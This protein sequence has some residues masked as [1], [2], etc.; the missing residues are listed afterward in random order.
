M[1][2][3]EL[4][5]LQ[6]AFGRA[7]LAGTAAPLTAALVSDRIPAERRFAVHVNT[8]YGLLG[9]ALEAAFP[10][11]C[12]LVGTPFFRMTTR[13]F[14]ADHPPEVP[15]L[16]VFGD[17]FPD[18]LASFPPAAG[19]PY[20]AGVA[21]LEWARVEA[22]FAADASPLDP[23]TLQSVPPE[24]VAALVFRLHPSVRLIRSPWPICDVW[25][26]HLQ[27]PVPPVDVTKGGQAALVLRPADAVQVVALLP[28]DAAL[29]DA[30]AGGAS[31]AA[32]ASAAS[33]AEPG[34]DLQA[35]L[36]GHLARGTFTG[37]A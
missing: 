35:A 23:A 7:L 20:L 26:A 33:E 31:L 10:V 18:F 21:R 34:F 28:G 36:A 14:I 19:V 6:A 8:V 9:D 17:R 3:P 25:F 1:P 22:G 12:R 30:I 5:E 37:H 27:D 29:I 24:D 16:A 15:H 13:A 11:A 32:A 2:P 4:H